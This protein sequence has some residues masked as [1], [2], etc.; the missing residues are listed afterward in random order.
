MSINETIFELYD[1]IDE[2]SLENDEKLSKELD[3][4]NNSWDKLPEEKI[5][6]TDRTLLAMSMMDLSLKVKNYNL[7]KKWTDIYLYKEN[8]Q[9]ISDLYNGQLAFYQQKYDIAYKLFK[10]A[11]DLSNGRI[12]SERKEF[13]D[14]IKNPDK[15]IKS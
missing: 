1:H 3:Y 14:L 4:V 13:L 12:F 5:E 15:Y 9:E 7:A 8:N 10:S 2:Y 11:F 6:D